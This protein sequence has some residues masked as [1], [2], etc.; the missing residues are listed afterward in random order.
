MDRKVYEIGK[1]LVKLETKG[2]VCRFLLSSLRAI[3]TSIS[4]FLFN[5][6]YLKDIILCLILRETVRRMEEIC[7]QK[8]FECLAASE[9]EKD[10]LTAILITFCVSI[11]LTSIDSFFLRKRFFKT[12]IWLDMVFG[13]LSPVLPAIYHFRLSQMRF[14]LDRQK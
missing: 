6:D 7:V 1:W 3:Q 13:F 11:A 9:V 5:L 4:P 2:K 8:D 10:I 12:N 14:Q